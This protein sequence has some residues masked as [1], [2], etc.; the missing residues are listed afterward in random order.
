MSKIS[1]HFDEFGWP[2]EERVLI[3]DN[4]SDFLAISVFFEKRHAIK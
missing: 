1:Q 4:V 3:E 2:E